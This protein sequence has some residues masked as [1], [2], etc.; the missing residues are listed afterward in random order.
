M[1]RSGSCA[2]WASSRPRTSIL[3]GSSALQ[4]WCVMHP[5][6]DSGPIFRGG[7]DEESEVFLLRC[8]GAIG[9]LY[10][11]VSLGLERRVTAGQE[12][13]CAELS[14]YLARRRS[15]GGAQGS[16]KRRAIPAPLHFQ[17]MPDTGACGKP[18]GMPHS[19][20][21]QARN[22][23]A[24]GSKMHDE[25]ARSVAIT[26]HA[27]VIAGG[28]PTGLMLAGELA[29]ARVDVAMVERRARQ[30]LAGSRAGGLHSRTIEVLDQRG[31][32]DRFLSCS[33]PHGSVEI[34]RSFDEAGGNAEVAAGSAWWVA[35][36]FRWGGS[37][38]CETASGPLCVARTRRRCRG[39]GSAGRSG[40]PT[41]RGRRRRETPSPTACRRGWW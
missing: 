12:T 19:S 8:E 24:G 23:G 32:A 30:D 29:L 2:P 9:A 27:V 18:R 14:P 20:R 5:A 15:R 6:S 25:S 10:T 22:A 39:C 28:G 35:T 3:K 40:R 37:S 26:K 34:E 21:P 41:R 11:G 1:L 17:L 33:R 13:L 38:W 7:A 4:S 36:R 31:I 16:E